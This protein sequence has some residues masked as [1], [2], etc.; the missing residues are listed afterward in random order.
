[1]LTVRKQNIYFLNCLSQ[2]KCGTRA[3]N[4]TKLGKT[5]EN[6][7]QDSSRLMALGNV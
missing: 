2:M 1:M 5:K 7:E 3:K 4:K 6:E